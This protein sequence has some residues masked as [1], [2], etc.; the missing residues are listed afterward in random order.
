MQHAIKFLRRQPRHRSGDDH[1]IREEL[2]EGKLLHP[3]HRLHL[4]AR[5]VPRRARQQP[6]AQSGGR[7]FIGHRVHHAEL[8]VRGKRR[9]ELSVG[10]AHHER[11]AAVHAGVPQLLEHFRQCR[12]GCGGGHRLRRRAQSRGGIVN[13]RGVLDAPHRWL[14]TINRALARADIQPP[15]RHRDA[16]RL[17]VHARPPQHALGVRVLR[18]DHAILPQQDRPARQRDHVG[19]ARVG[20]ARVN[21]DADLRAVV[22]LPEFRRRDAHLRDDIFSKSARACAGDEREG[23]QHQ[24]VLVMPPERIHR[25]AINRDRRGRSGRALRTEDARAPVH[26][27]GGGVAVGDDERVVPQQKIPLRIRAGRAVGGELTV[28]PAHHLL[29][30]IVGRRMV[31]DGHVRQAQ[32]VIAPEHFSRVGREGIDK[33]AFHVPHPRHAIHHAVGHEHSGAHRPARNHAVI[34]HHALVARRG[35]KFPHQFSR[36][37][38]EAINKP[39]VRGEISPAPVQV[40]REPHRPAR[41]EMPPLGSRLRIERPHR[42]IR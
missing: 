31:H 34:A 5:T 21:H 28:V 14:E 1:G 18:H 20:F 26:G 23:I 9:R 22:N 35:L 32:R 24:H 11:E 25:A 10:V 12:R 30:R 4:H 13:R 19:Q 37:R 17:A 29:A 39:I 16:A 33:H 41:D 40:R 7:G 27:G 8:R 38:C 3:P 6:L 36:V 42:V 2:R 15:V